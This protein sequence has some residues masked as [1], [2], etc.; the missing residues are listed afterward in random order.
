MRN[1]WRAWKIRD[2]D[3][4]GNVIK[5]KSRMV[6]R[7]FGQ[8]YNV[9]FFETLAPTPSAASVKIAVAV[10]NLNGWLRRRLDVKQAFI[11][12]HLNEAV[13]YTKLPAGYGDM[14]GEV[15]LLQRAVYELRQTGSQ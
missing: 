7:V 3:N 15:V 12:A 14:S 6:A 2:C 4:L 11:Q 8:I 10:A 9:V 13:Y 5:P 1:L